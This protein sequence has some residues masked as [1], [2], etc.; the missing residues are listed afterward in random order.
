MERL[1]KKSFKGFTFQSKRK[2]GVSSAAQTRCL[3]AKLLL[4]YL[5]CT[6]HVLSAYLFRQAFR[7]ACCSRSASLLLSR[8]FGGNIAQRSVTVEGDRL[9]HYFPIYGK[10]LCSYPAWNSFVS[11]ESR[12]WLRPR[13]CCPR[14]Q[15]KRFARSIPS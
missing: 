15:Q 2:G 14:I 12:N 1:L 4:T 6:Q 7:C 9:K 10:R 11:A 3:L 13:F 8:S 5:C